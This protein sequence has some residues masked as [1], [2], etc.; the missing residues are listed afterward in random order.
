[1]KNLLILSSLAVSLALASGQ[2]LAADQD[3]ERDR[4]QI[5]LQDNDQDQLNDR[6]RDRVR[7]QSQLKN[8]DNI[9]G[10][11][12]MTPQERAEHRA[13]M[14]S[15]TTKQEREQIRNEH[16]EQMKIRA[17]ARGITLPDQAPAIGAGSMKGQGGGK[18]SGGG[19]R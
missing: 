2:I 6:D 12:L 16:H 9:Y 5:Q 13:K 10:S 19:G 7:D 15:A 1:M 8:Q 11:Q 18:G 4:D 17:K 3:R 14:Q